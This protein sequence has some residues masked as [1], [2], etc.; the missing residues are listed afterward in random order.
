MKRRLWVV[1]IL[2]LAAGGA[3]WAFRS[4]QR[5]KELV[6]SGTIEARDVEVGS[7]VGGRV[8]E[9]LVSEGQA[10]RAGQPVVK[11]ETDLGALQIRE[12][13]AVV[14]QARANLAKMR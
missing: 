2:A 13:R 12:Q 11:F 7:L 4:R 14:D 6:F 10:V 5:E 9:V 1:V 8:A 3:F